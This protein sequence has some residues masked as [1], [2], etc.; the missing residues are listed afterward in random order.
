MYEN[1][2]S[3]YHSTTLLKLV[4]ML[5][6]ILGGGLPKIEIFIGTITQLKISYINSTALF[7]QSL[8]W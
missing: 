3:T 7:S 1:Y 5:S 4:A 8:E 2:A 6:E